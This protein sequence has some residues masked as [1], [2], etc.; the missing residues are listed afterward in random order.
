MYLRDLI[1]KLVS[2]M[3]SILR[4]I[5]SRIEPSNS[6]KREGGVLSKNFFKLETSDIIMLESLSKFR[7]FSDKF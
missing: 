7:I 4:Y 5:K 6:L 3:L 1:S 2:F